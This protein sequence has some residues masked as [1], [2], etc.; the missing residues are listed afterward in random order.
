MDAPLAELLVRLLYA[1]IASAVFGV[2]LYGWRYLGTYPAAALT[3]YLTIIVGMNALWRW[4]VLW[5][6]MQKDSDGQWS[7]DVEPMVRTLG[8]ALLIL[9]YIAIG[10]LAFFHIR[11]IGKDRDD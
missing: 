8:N 7:V 2:L 3:R 4:Y 11:R 6:G 5:I 10:L 9:L 1:I